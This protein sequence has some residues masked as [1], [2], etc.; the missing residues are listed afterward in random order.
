MFRFAAKMLD[1][2]GAAEDVVQEVFVGPW[3]KLAQLNDATLVGWL[4]RGTA[5]RCVNVIRAPQADV[6][7][8]LPRSPRTDAQPEHAALISGRLA[9]LTEAL[10][11]LTSQQRACWLLH[12]VHGRSYEEIAEVV[13]AHPV[14]FR[15][16]IARARVQP[17]EVMKPWR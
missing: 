1:H 11:Q 6:D 12:E 17:A 15:G 13:G 16:R 3:R 4:Y 5:D 8:D 2:R 14:A 10:R 9:V 7:L